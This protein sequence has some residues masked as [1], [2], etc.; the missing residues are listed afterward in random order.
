MLFRSGQIR[1]ENLANLITG[2]NSRTTF[3]GPATV[4]A[5]LIEPPKRALRIHLITDSPAEELARPWTQ[6]A[7]TERLHRLAGQLAEHP[8]KRDLLLAQQHDPKPRDGYWGPFWSL[9][10]ACHLGQDRPGA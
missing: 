5:T 1:H 10:M 7:A 8:D 6:A 4:T 9:P 3:A 2:A